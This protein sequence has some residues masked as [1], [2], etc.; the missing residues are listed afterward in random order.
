MDRQSRG[1][2]HLRPVPAMLKSSHK[3]KSNYFRPYSK[4]NF[5]KF[6]STL[7]RSSSSLFIAGFLG[8]LLLRWLTADIIVFHFNQRRKVLAIIRTVNT[9]FL[10]ERENA[11]ARNIPYDISRFNYPW[12]VPERIKLLDLRSSRNRVLYSPIKERA[13]NGLGHNFATLNGELWTALRLNL[14][15]THRLT[16][17]AVLSIPQNHTRNL[18]ATS[19][20]SEEFLHAGSVEQLLGWGVG[21]IPREH[22]QLSICPDN[23]MYSHDMKCRVCRETNVS[24]TTSN[25]LLSDQ[26]LNFAVPIQHIVEVP[27]NLSYNYPYKARP[28]NI[29]EA[30]KF[31][32]NH[33]QPNTVFVLPESMCNLNPVYTSFSPHQRSFFFHKYWDTHEEGAPRLDS[34]KYRNESFLQYKK[35]VTSTRKLGIV[36]RRNDLHRLDPSMINIGVHLRRGDFFSV[37]TRKMVPLKSVARL[38]CKIEKIVRKEKVFRF[39]S[40]PLLVQ[41]YSEGVV[42][43]HVPASTNKIQTE[44]LRSIGLHNRDHDVNKLGKNLVDVDGAVYSESDVTAIVRNTG[45]SYCGSSFASGLNVKLRVSDNTALSVHEMVASDIFIGSNSSLSLYLIS[46]LSKAAFMLLPVKGP[47]FQRAVTFDSSSGK[48]T[49]AATETLTKLWTGYAKFNNLL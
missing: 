19:A 3:L 22:V 39:S 11:R 48:L 13:R 43:K 16:N 35:R 4:L 21:E 32:E 8:F 15:Y 27:L 12:I 20:L 36:G 25:Q 9:T 47:S 23:V 42:Q 14:T 34:S 1:V 37:P 5:V 24:H 41:I 6:H 40:M 17:Y 28:N 7:Q 49:H 46:S 26:R 29:K 30:I 44:S 18:N 33:S 31:I 45:F 2:K 38:I 10:L